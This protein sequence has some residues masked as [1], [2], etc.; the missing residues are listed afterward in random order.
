MFCNCFYICSLSTSQ[1]FQTWQQLHTRTYS[2]L[3]LVHLMHIIKENGT[4]HD[5]N[6]SAC[7]TLC[8]LRYNVMN[9]SLNKL[10]CVCYIMQIASIVAWYVQ[11]RSWIVPRSFLPAA[12]H[13][14]RHRTFVEVSN[15][16]CSSLHLQQT[17]WIWQI[18]RSHCEQQRL[19][20][21]ISFLC[22]R[23]LQLQGLTCS[24]YLKDIDYWCL[25]WVYAHM[26]HRCFIWFLF[27]CNIV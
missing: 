24:F 9:L 2:L 26:P 23:T 11:P 17:L 3:S 4:Y 1:D 12:V 5:K 20:L 10:S 7:V 14:L 22:V 16:R 8:I 27:I 13:V 15:G 19:Q 18:Q 6:T 25:S 21:V